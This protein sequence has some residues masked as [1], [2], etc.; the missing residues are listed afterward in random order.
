MSD[1][2]RHVI[3]GGVTVGEK[4]GRG[5][6]IKKCH[7]FTKLMTVGKCKLL[8]WESPIIVNNVWI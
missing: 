8:C 3:F 7:H 5:N 1:L 6:Q 2:T 4:K